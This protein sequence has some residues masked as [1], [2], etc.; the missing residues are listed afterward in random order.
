MAG[1][2][3]F[4]PYPAKKIFVGSIIAIIIAIWLY[5]EPD[6]VEYGSFNVRFS[7]LLSGI[8]S[9]IV[10]V[11]A[12]DKKHTAEQE[13]NKEHSKEQSTSAIIICTKCSQRLRLPS[14]K[15]LE[16][17]CPKCDNI[18]RIHT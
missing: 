11:I 17:R 4:G 15:N 12:L 2:K 7:L 9:L 18:F 13:N 10:S 6:Y 14:G 8:L 5:L 3:S 1:I 16:V